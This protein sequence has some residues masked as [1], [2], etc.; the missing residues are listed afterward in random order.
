MMCTP[1]SLFCNTLLSVS[2]QC[3]ENDDWGGFGHWVAKKIGCPDVLI[4]VPTVKLK[5]S[6]MAGKQ[7]LLPYT[8]AEKDYLATL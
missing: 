6:F 4:V 3:P 2:R 1:L 8:A 5:C 7:T